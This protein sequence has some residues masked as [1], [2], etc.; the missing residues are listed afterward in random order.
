MSNNITNANIQPFKNNK[1]IKKEFKLDNFI[2]DTLPK[3]PS[4]Y[5]DRGENIITS[6]FE[7]KKNIEELK[8]IKD[9]YNETFL[10]L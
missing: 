9:F 8:L 5:F 3:I 2:N 4:F 1:V 7:I 10:Y 6:Y